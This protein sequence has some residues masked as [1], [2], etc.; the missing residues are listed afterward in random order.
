MAETIVEPTLP[1]DASPPPPAREPVGMEL[2]NDTISPEDIALQDAIKA[3]EAG[4]TQ[5]ADP[6]EGA[7]GEQPGAQ[8]EPPQ[9]A[10][11][12]PAQAGAGRKPVMVPIERLNEALRDRDKYRDTSIYLEGRIAA[13]TEGQAPKQPGEAPATAAPA[14]A[15]QGPM[16]VE[17]LKE[18][19]RQGRM[20]IQ[21]QYDDATLNSEQYAQKSA[22]LDALLI[23]GIA[24]IVAQAQ[25][26]AE[27]M[28]DRAVQDLHADKLEAEHPYVK[29]VQAGGKMDALVA[30]VDAE[31]RALGRYGT[32]RSKTEQN[33][34]FREAVARL[35]DTK[36]PE[37]FPDAQVPT[38]PAATTPGKP[39]LTPQA[40]ARK[41]KLDLAA[42]LPPDISTFGK[43]G[44][45]PTQLTEEQILNMPA[46]E[47]EKLDTRLYAH[48]LQ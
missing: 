2:R 43:P 40:A 36:G 15:P 9:E 31:W 8:A 14:E 33:M 44:Q 45:A 32:Y 35:A 3:A 5:D 38:K 13:I 23:D 10:E 6:Q 29:V 30:I 46:H 34:A 20:Q 19:V 39:A 4:E 16:T 27:P 24:T 42:G 7:P 12:Q 26:Q 37:W 1:Q 47:L 11:P 48:L 22:E 41:A 17:A 28:T 18:R 21:Q 25:A